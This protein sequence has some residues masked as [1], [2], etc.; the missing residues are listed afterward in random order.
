MPLQASKYSNLKISS[1]SKQFSFTKIQ[2]FSFREEKCFFVWSYDK[3]IST[4]WHKRTFTNCAMYALMQKF[5]L[6]VSLSQSDSNL[7]SKREHQIAIE[8]TYC[9]TDTSSYRFDE[10]FLRIVKIEHR[11]DQDVSSINSLIKKKLV[12]AQMTA[13]SKTCM[14]FFFCLLLSFVRSGRANLQTLGRALI[15]DDS[16]WLRR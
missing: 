14:R 10:L 4:F 13:N 8:N 3:N 12:E 5:T 7:K 6:I 2:S 1:L 9:W 16:V 11:I 15:L